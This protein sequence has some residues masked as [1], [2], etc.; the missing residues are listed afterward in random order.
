MFVQT[1]NFGFTVTFKKTY[2]IQWKGCI[3]RALHLLAL[4]EQADA[5]EEQPDALVIAEN[6][7]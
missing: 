1:L 5:L 3:R 7:I 2:L 4:E 6:G